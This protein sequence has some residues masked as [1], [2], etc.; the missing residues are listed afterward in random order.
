MNFEKI[1]TIF[2][3]EK[4]LVNARL[5]YM[6]ENSD[7]NNFVFLLGF[8]D[9]DFLKFR[10]QILLKKIKDLIKK[11]TFSQENPEFSLDFLLIQVFFQ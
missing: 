5:L 10:L 8:E 1:N 9:G 7:I 2:A 3:Q 11:K 6:N 4:K